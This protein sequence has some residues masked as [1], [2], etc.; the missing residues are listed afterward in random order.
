MHM[1]NDYITDR[2][3]VDKLSSLLKSPFSEKPGEFV[4]LRT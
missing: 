2:S 4:E 3:L 1:L